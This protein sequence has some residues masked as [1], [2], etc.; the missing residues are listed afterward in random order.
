[1]V[2]SIKDSV[3][4]ASATFRILHELIL[5]GFHI[6]YFEFRTGKNLRKFLIKICHW[7]IQKSG[8]VNC[9]L[10]YFYR[11]E[12][13]LLTKAGEEEKNSKSYFYI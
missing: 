3:E 13:C 11:L 6:E 5:K 4:T 12:L 1:M 10:A 2:N 9:F 7:G 8:W